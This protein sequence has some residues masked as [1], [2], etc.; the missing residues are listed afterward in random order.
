MRKYSR[1]KETIKVTAETTGSLKQKQNY[2]MCAAVVAKVEPG[3]L[4]FPTLK[5]IKAKQVGSFSW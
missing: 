1:E 4:K 5:N 3:K 2:Q